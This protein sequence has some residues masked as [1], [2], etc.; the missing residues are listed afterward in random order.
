[1]GAKA[2]GI[3]M[4]GGNAPGV[5][6]VNGGSVRDFMSGAL[7]RAIAAGTAMKPPIATAATASADVAAA[8]AAGTKARKRAVGTVLGKPG[9]Y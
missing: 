2:L 8:T 1:M 5:P 7:R 6:L 4:G 3:G 9:G